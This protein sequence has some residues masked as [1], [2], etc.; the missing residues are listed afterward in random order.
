MTGYAIPPREYAEWNNFWFE[1]GSDFTSPRVFLIGDSITVG[2]RAK[3]Q[4]LFRA[5]GSDILVDQSAG[6]RCAGDPALE[7]EIEYALGPV[8]GYRYKV[9]HFNN[10]L[11]GGC[12]DTLIDTEKYEAG[13]RRCIALIR[14]LQPDAKLILATSTVLLTSRDAAPGSIDYKKNS[15]VFHRNEVIHNLAAELGLPIDDLFGAVTGNPEYT[16]PDG[17]HYAEAGRSRLAESV[18]ASIEAA[19]AE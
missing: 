2:Y 16:Q 8:N 5:A 11:H 1:K 13:M 18:K 17:V 6:S 9:V 4:E 7:A 19:L 15:F 3:V 14:R 10:G 12:N